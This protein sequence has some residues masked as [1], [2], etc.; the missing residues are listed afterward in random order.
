MINIVKLIFLSLFIWSCS[1]F[2]YKKQLIRSFYIVEHES[3]KGKSLIRFYDGSNGDFNRLIGGS[4]EQFGF[5]KDTII[6]FE[7]R[8]NKYF[9]LDTRFV[10]YQEDMKEITKTE[11]MKLI[12]NMKSIHTYSTDE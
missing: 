9:L 11:F 12:E 4:I 6:V 7:T 10:K 1:D 8:K 5:N 3:S 2:K